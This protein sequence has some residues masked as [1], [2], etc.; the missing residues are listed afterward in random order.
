ML[1]TIG[2]DPMASR[3]FF[4]ISGKNADIKWSPYENDDTNSKHDVFSWILKSS[5]FVKVFWH[6][7]QT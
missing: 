3:I 7:L 4:D 2:G 6:L 1:L 5:M